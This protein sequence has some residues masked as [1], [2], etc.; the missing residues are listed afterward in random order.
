MSNANLFD[1]LRDSHAMQRQLCRRLTR[2]RDPRQR[3]SLF[4]QLK[5]ELEAHAAAEERYLYVPMLMTDAGLSATR[6]ALSEHH[7]IEELCEDLSVRDKSGDEWA[8]TMS[9]LSHK[10]HH[11]LREEERKFFKVGGRLLDSRQ[12]AQLARQYEDEIVR[13]RRRYAAA[14]RS[15]GVDTAGAVVP[16]GR[17]TASMPV[18][19]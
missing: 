1:A 15:V 12:K 3:E 10:V 9:A 17:A 8:G 11:H 19:A 18:V 16:S 6:H 14:Y 5:V 4:L 2:T 13:L 7:D